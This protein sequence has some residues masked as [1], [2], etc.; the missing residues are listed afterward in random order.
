MAAFIGTT[1]DA[2]QKE[3]GVELMRENRNCGN[4]RFGNSRKAQ[5]R[6]GPAVTFRSSE[7]TEPTDPERLALLVALS[8]RPE[9]PLPSASSIPAC[10]RR[11]LRS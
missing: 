4:Q 5:Y 9:S 8:L 7:V 11:K 2:T 3:I 10:L 6:L 1:W